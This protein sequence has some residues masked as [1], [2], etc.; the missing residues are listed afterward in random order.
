M[1]L[2]VCDLRETVCVW[3]IGESKTFLGIFHKNASDIQNAREMCNFAVEDSYKEK[4][5]R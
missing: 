4:I 5:A 1:F 2:R 3:F